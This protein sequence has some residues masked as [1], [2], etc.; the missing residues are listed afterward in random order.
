MKLFYTS[1]S[2]YARKVMV[3]AL[4]LGLDGQIERVPADFNTPGEEFLLANPLGKVPVLVR[5]DGRVLVDSPVICEY[6]DSLH[7]GVSLI[8]PK[9]DAR[10]DALHLQAM[11]DGTLDAAILYYNERNRPDGARSDAFAERQR[12]KMARG[13]D[14]F[15]ANLG[16]LD[17]PLHIGQIALA[18]SI[19]WIGLRIGRE[20]WAEDRPG[21]AAWFDQFSQRPSMQ[22]T[23][24]KDF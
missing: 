12:R 20:A 2:P 21:L 6:V 4:E 24:P 9:G 5:D 1:A 14:W 18:C 22:A 10:W 17:G 13:F 19:G 7:D 8:P 3:V 15:E 11:A 16:L 23:A